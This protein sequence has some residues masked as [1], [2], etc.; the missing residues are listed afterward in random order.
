MTRVN[1]SGACCHAWWFEESQH[2]CD[3]AASTRDSDN[4]RNDVKD[5]DDRVGQAM[6]DTDA[7]FA[8]DRLVPVGIA[9]DCCT[10]R[11]EDSDEDRQVGGSAPGR[12]PIEDIDD[13][14][15][16]GQR[17]RTQRDIRDH[18]MKWMPEPGPVDEGF[19]GVS[20]PAH[21]LVGAPDELLGEI[22]DWLQPA[23]LIDEPIDDMTQHTVLLSQSDFALTT[24]C[25]QESA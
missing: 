13:V 23:L 14:E 12:R 16:D 7:T 22:G 24:V 20:G 19:D 21:D 9:R 17:P 8:V 3:A 15:K 10:E 2:D 5:H 1:F 18:R 11:S 6:G 25:V 4:E